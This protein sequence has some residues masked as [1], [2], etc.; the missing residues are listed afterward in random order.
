MRQGNFSVQYTSSLQ[1]GQGWEVGH[2]H[3]PHTYRFMRRAKPNVVDLVLNHVAFV[4]V[5]P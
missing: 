3:T 4:S 2:T 5:S 1:R